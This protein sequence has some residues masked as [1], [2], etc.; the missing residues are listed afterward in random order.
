M[1][2]TVIT[3]FSNSLII[4]TGAILNFIFDNSVAGWILL[5]L[6]GFTVILG[7]ILYRKC[8]KDKQYDTGRGKKD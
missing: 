2:N 1:D 3:M 5:G 7:I 6:F 4:L 8:K